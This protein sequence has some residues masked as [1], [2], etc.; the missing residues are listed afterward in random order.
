[1]D[2]ETYERLQQIKQAYGFNNA[3]ELVA[4]FVHILLDRIEIAEQRKYDLP[5]DDGRY[6]DKMFDD[7][8]NVQRTPN[9]DVPVRH[10]AKRI[11]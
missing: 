11:K 1:M 8:G 2:S 7:L 5:D 9:G 6:I 10:P 3:C 4:A